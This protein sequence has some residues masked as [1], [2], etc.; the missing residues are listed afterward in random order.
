MPIARVGQFL[1]TDDLGIVKSLGVESSQMRACIAAINER[2]IAGIFSSPVFGFL[3]D[4]LDFLCEVRNIRQVWFWEI[5]LKRIDKLYE[6]PKLEYF[7]IHDKRPP[8]DFSRFRHLTDVVWHPIRGDSGL[9]QLPQ[10]ARLDIWRLK[11]QTKD[12]SDLSLPQSLRKLEF[13]WCNQESSSSLPQMPALEDL[14][15]HYCRN[16]RSLRGLADQAPNLKK[17]V[18][19]R[20]ANLESW[21]EAL[22][23]PLEH[24]Y[25]N[26]RGK[27]VA[28]RT[29]KI[30]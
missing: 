22:K 29:A 11:N 18:I 9:A 10:L 17:L 15:F 8:I 26:V 14:Q 16:L 5:A 2:R 27:T 23:L 21:D 13:N 6:Q 28:H 25:I 19:T 7:G 1:E 4:N 20:C 12:F 30:S 24:L 3:D